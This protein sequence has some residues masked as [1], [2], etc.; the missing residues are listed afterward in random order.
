[1]KWSDPAAAA[2]VRDAV[3]VV[4]SDR[5][6]ALRP[7]PKYATVQTIERQ[8]RRCTVIYAGEATPVTVM[9]G[10]IQP[11]HAGQIVRVGG[12][13]GGRYVEDVMGDSFSLNLSG[14]T[15]T[16]PLTLSGAPSSNLH[17]ATKQYVDGFFPVTNTNLGSRAARSVI[18]RSNTT[19]GTPADITAGTADTVLRRSGNNALDFGKVT[20]AMLSSTFVKTGLH[21]AR[22]SRTGALN[23]ANTSFVTV[24]MQW[25]GG[26]SG[27]TISTANGTI[28]IGKTARYLVSHQVAWQ[29]SNAGSRWAFVDDGTGRLGQEVSRAHSESQVLAQSGIWMGELSIN[30]V[31]K[32]V[33]YQTSGATTQVSNPAGNDA[34]C[35]IAVHELPL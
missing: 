31:L 27:P 18:G 29:S 23:I 19:T 32:L 25:D 21:Y 13:P 6:E 16:G 26:A 20:D 10:S 1:M 3:R 34:R 30:T 2:A 11:R 33:V 9:M 24:T 8:E 12:P 28:T 17:A 15:L 14:G 4:V 22:M 5:M 35:E 7:A